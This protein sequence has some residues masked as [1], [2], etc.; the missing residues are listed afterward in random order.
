MTLENKIKIKIAILGAGIAGLCAAIA[1]HKKG[2]SVTVYERN[3]KPKNIGAG[4]VLWPNASEIL[5]KLA[6][7]SDIK[8]VALTLDKMQRW[9]D[10]DEFLNEIDLS[11]IAPK[12]TYS[13]H[14]IS[15]RALHKILINHSSKNKIKI[16]YDYPV[17]D[18]KTQKDNTAEVYFN[19][20]NK[21]NADIIIGADGR[22]NSIARQYVTG[23]NNP[24]YQGYVNWV[25]IVPADCGIEFNQHIM[26]Y[27]GCGERFGIVPLSANS[28]YWAGCKVLPK[29]LGEP[30]N[31]SK[32]TLLALFKHWPSTI[33][34]IIKATPE[35]QIQRIEVY[36]LEPLTFWHK[37]NVCL[38]GDAAHAALPTSGQGACQAIEDAYAL[39]ELLAQSDM[40]S[41][42]DCNSAFKALFKQRSAITNNITLSARQLTQSIFNSDP[43]FCK[44]RNKQAAAQHLIHKEG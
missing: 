1:L 9:T 27:W 35:Q 14:A 16:H 12:I 31:G 18:I 40:N 6:L 3:S 8:S 30:N 4:L 5:D 39:A 11:T 23:N 32:N 34:A 37:N 25:G 44:H 38:I 36:D 13:N 10:S 20:Q 17:V 28:A 41:K 21:I 26:D 2:F 22:M 42:L 29:G 19:N 33:E 7:L 24:I 15:R 43:E